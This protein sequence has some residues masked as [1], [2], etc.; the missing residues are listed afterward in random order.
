MTQKEIIRAWRDLDAREASVKGEIPE[1]PAGIVELSD[2][3]LGTVVGGTNTPITSIVTSI[4]A[5]VVSFSQFWTAFASCNE[6][7]PRSPN[8][9]C[10]LA[11]FGCCGGGGS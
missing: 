1:N 6:G 8:G 10:R 5:S 7:C 11:T 3:D 2:E 4:I 9:T